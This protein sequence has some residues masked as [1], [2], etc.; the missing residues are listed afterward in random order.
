[1]TRLSIQDYW[2]RLEK[3]NWFYAWIQDGEE[4]DEHATEAKRLFHLSRLSNKHGQLYTAYW[5]GTYLH[6]SMEGAEVLDIELPLDGRPEA[7]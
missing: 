2:E 7:A 5:T 4:Y 1:M 6:V 3:H